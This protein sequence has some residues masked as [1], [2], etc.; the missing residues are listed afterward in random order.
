MVVSATD[1]VY[2]VGSSRNEQLDVAAG[3]IL[4]CGLAYCVIGFVVM[5]FGVR[6]VEM[7][8][9]PGKVTVF[10]TRERKTELFC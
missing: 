6:W 2:D 9:P 4:V 3:G 7:L 10:I 1:Y 8:M 5:I